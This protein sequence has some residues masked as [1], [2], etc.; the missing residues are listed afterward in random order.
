MGL[1][2]L[3]SNMITS[4][5]IK[6][7]AILSVAMLVFDVQPITAQDGE[8]VSL[9]ASVTVNQEDGD[10][11]SLTVNPFADTNADKAGDGVEGVLIGRPYR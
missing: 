6:A 8:V 3:K 10:V 9:E 1:F 2:G 4:K 5:I 11:A 7:A